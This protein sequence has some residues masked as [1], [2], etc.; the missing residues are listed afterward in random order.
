[1]SIT[2]CGIQ[3]LWRLFNRNI[4]IVFDLNYFL[5]RLKTSTRHRVSFCWKS[6][7]KFSI[8]NEFNSLR[9]GSNIT[10]RW[11]LVTCWWLPLKFWSPTLNLQ[12]QLVTSW[13]QFRTLN[14][15]HSHNQNVRMMSSVLFYPV[16]LNSHKTHNQVE[17][18]ECAVGNQH[19]KELN[20]AED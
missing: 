5:W 13:S 17:N 8:Q 18:N 2:V 10:R 7:A 3:L 15:S 20:K 19:W 1:M 12:S 16:P 4:A 14:D 11:K 6:N 9:A